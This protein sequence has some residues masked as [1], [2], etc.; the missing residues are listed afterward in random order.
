MSSVE[1]KSEAQK[2]VAFEEGDSPGQK[3]ANAEIIRSIFGETSI[4]QSRAPNGQFTRFSGETEATGTAPD[5]GASDDSRGIKRQREETAEEGSSTGGGLAPMSSVVEKNL[6]VNDSTP[7]QMS[8]SEYSKY[9]E[10]EANMKAMKER[11]SEVASKAEALDGITRAMGTKNVGEV[12]R[13]LAKAQETEGKKEAELIDLSVEKLD[14]LASK[15]TDPTY[16]NGLERLSG[17]FKKLRSDPKNLL[18][19]G[20]ESD[21][22]PIITSMVAASMDTECSLVNL[23]RAEEENKELKRVLEE[24]RKARITAETRLGMKNR[25]HLSSAPSQWHVHAS[26][27]ATPASSAAGIPPASGLGRLSSFSGY[28]ASSGS[29]SGTSASSMKS[30]AGTSSY[31]PASSGHIFGTS[32][33]SVDPSSAS[34]GMSQKAMGKLPASSGSEAMSVEAP[35]TH[36]AEGSDLSGAGVVGFN[37]AGVVT[38]RSA[39]D[40][41]RGNTYDMA[42]KQFLQRKRNVSRFKAFETAEERKAASMQQKEVVA[43]LKDAPS[44]PDDPRMW[45]SFYGL[46][47]SDYFVPVQHNGIIFA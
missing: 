47:E 27:D 18:T 32:A 26:R 20:Y 31:V 34:S 10:M 44:M 1:D 19:T 41:M 6:P 11:L 21:I 8:A 3:G 37:E 24:E 14:A 42:Y 29:M 7:V 28:S 23:A 2:K 25:G 12:E 39:A 13:F 43:A 35:T 4:R 38:F 46:K 16:K 22:K 45:Q 15:V 40:A 5:E 33:S 36:H 30:M 9:V 17:M